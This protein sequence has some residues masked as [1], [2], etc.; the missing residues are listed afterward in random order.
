MKE[1]EY[2]TESEETGWIYLPDSMED[3][4]ERERPLVLMLCAPGTSPSDKL[5]AAGWW[6]QAAMYTMFPP[7]CP[8]WKRSIS[9]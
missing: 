1:V 7:S 6:K 4:P 8:P 3:D 5:K 9:S 2:T